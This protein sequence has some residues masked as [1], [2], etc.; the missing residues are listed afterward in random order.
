MFAV[1]FATSLAL[2]PFIVPLV[3]WFYSAL[4][5]DLQVKL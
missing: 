4:E 3:L 1:A 2:L 5:S